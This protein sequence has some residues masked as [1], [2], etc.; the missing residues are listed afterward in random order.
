MVPWVSN[1]DLSPTRALA[2]SSAAAV[3][4][5]M[6]ALVGHAETFAWYQ[7]HGG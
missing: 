2:Y 6:I 5:A 3:G 4:P 7:D 1:I